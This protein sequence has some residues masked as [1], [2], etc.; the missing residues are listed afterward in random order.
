VARRDEVHVWRAALDRPA[1]VVGALWA[2]LDDDERDRAERLR[3]PPARDRFVVA[4]G[5]LRII[6][7]RYLAI[8]PAAV[9]FSYGVSGK[10]GLAGDTA[11]RF[12]LS[13]SGPLALYAVAST[14]DVGIDVERIRSDVDAAALTRRFFTPR[15]AA[16]LAHLP[17]AA[18][19]PAFF[20]GWTRKEAVVKAGG[21]GLA[22]SLAEVDVGDATEVDGPDGRRWRLEDL[23]P[24]PG[25]A[26]ALAVEG[27][28]WRLRCWE[29]DDRGRVRTRGP[30]GSA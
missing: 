24:A 12:N 7:A 19:L 3:R 1:A 10:P 27:G 28:D 23:T 13:H 22:R 11:L 15:E 26:A 25:Y 17:A 14:R 29:G 4:H 8:A 16:A 18:R 21:E 6:L 20:T 5:L 30:R 9:R 2:S